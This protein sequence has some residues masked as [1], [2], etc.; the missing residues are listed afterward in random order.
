MFYFLHQNHLQAFIE[1]ISSFGTYVNGKQVLK[2]DKVH[3]S[4]GDEI[5]L[6]NEKFIV[7]EI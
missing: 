2:N 3:I 7:K 1:D 5:T 4:N 6:Y